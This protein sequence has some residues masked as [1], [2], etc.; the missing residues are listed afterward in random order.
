MASCK[1][2]YYTLLGV[3]IKASADEINKAYK[4]LALRWHP[5]K[6]LNDLEKAQEVFQSIT[7]AHGVLSDPQK[8]RIYDI[9][10]AQSTYEVLSEQ[11]RRRIYEMAG[12]K[13]MESS[14]MDPRNNDMLA[15]HRLNA[16]MDPYRNGQDYG[17]G[18]V[19]HTNRNGLGGPE[20]VQIYAPQG[21]LE[22]N[23]PYNRG[24]TQPQ[25][26]QSQQSAYSARKNN[27]KILGFG[28]V[29][30]LCFAFIGFAVIGL[31]GLITFIVYIWY[32]RPY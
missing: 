30:W 32:N 24:Y 13:N 2:D 5:D 22:Q 4:K 21:N 8:R 16:F 26:Y 20:F 7:E 27:K 15:N 1:D 19:G 12:D 23:L 18:L 11:D 10:R 14:S 6:N 3:E 31:I 9:E 28:N 25:T 29:D 17:G